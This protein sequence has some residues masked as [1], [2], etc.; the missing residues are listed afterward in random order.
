ML[1]TYKGAS[2][3][4]HLE[5]D[6]K[7]FRLTPSQPV[8]IAD[9]QADALQKRPFI[10]ALIE[11]GELEFSED[12]AAKEAAKAKAKEEAQKKSDAEAEAA[13]V[14]AQSEVDEKAKA[15]AEAEAKVKADEKPADDKPV[16]KK[17]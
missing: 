11:A 1:V 10:K 2:T 17:K 12:E 5:V 3:A 7:A 4:L 6:G 8:D 13:K 15:D 9:K 14:K 16:V